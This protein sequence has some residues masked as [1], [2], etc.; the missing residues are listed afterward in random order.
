M[1]GNI[2]SLAALYMCSVLLIDSIEHPQVS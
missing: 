1:K 2:L